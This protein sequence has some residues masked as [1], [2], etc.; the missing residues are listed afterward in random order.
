MSDYLFKEL[1]VLAE[2][3]DQAPVPP[4]LLERIRR[5]LD[6]LN[7]MAKLGGYSHEYEILSRYVGWVLEVPWQKQ[8]EERL[9]LAVAQKIL[10]K[11]HYGLE[12]V[13][14]RVLEYL[15]VR[16]LKEGKDAPPAGE[17]D[18]APIICLVGLQGVGKT[19]LAESMA[20]A[21]NR[22]FVRV[23]LGALGSILELRGQ[24]RSI[25]AAE[26]GQIVKALV[27]AEVKNPLILLDEL[28]KVSGERGLR[29][30][31]MASLLE[32]LDPEQNTTFRD[33]YLD[34][35]FDLSEVMFVASA[36]NIGTFSAALMDRLEIIRM[37][38]YTDEQKETIAREYLLPKVLRACGLQEA[39]LRFD[40][41]VW[42][43]LI[44]PLG[45]DSGIRSLQRN[46]DGICRKAAKLKVEGRKEPVVISE[47]NFK[48]YLPEW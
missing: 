24:T 30:D 46:L 29:S 1:E 9:D 25:P 15:A 31:I 36:N 4:D 22:H 27:R 35:P 7:R 8:T 18:H 6:R 11:N 23:S 10:D 42:P 21:L 47:G 12:R 13:K 43:K 48:E 26:P 45:Y 20:E 44:R 28:D 37:P 40:E 3:I 19:T 17:E 38:S 39:D 41:A 14:E 2:K 16:L 32:I 33:H 34:Y 5:M